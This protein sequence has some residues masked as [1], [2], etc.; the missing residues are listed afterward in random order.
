MRI[1]VMAAG[2]LGGYFG[3]RLAAAGHDVFFIARG[4]NLEAIRRNGMKLVMHDGA[5]HVARNVEATNDYAAAGPQDSV[6]RPGGPAPAPGRREHCD[7][8][9]AGC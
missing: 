7:T 9:A 3:A 1:A 6:R 5:E 8:T 2:A 4:A